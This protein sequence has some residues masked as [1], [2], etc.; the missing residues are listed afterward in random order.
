M[1]TRKLAEIDLWTWLL[2]VL[3]AGVIGSIA[4]VALVSMHW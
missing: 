3:V 4:T 1:K 2:I